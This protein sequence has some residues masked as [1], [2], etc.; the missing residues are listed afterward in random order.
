[1]GA[2]V[3]PSNTPSTLD[4]SAALALQNANNSNSTGSNAGATPVAQLVEQ[5][6]PNP[7]VAGSI[8]SRRV[9]APKTDHTSFGIYKFGQGYWVRM[10]TCVFA[11]V[12]ALSTAAWAWRS[13]EAVRPPTPT[14]QLNLDALPAAA[15][16]KVGESVTMLDTSKTPAQRVAS[17]TVKAVDP[18]IAG[19]A[20]IVVEKLQREVDMSGR[21]IDIAA[22]SNAFGPAVGTGSLWNARIID[23]QGIPAFQIVYV[24]AGVATVI[25]LIGGLLVYFYVGRKPSS[26]E[27]LISTDGEMRKVN[28]S[29]K[30]I[31]LDS[32]YVVIAASILIAGFIFLWDVLISNFFKIIHVV[33]G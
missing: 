14:W 3:P 4:V 9:P 15:M 1:M 10:M 5:R 30:K 16:P 31:I 25:L 12:L 28:W 22:A 11:G 29:T 19:R 24:Q 23:A 21:K 17:A 6:I 32:T 8:P 27:F 13:L 20:K 2:R 26:A 7:Q 18:G 33:R